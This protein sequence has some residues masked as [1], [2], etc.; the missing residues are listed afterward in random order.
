MESRLQEL[1][2]LYLKVFTAQSEYIPLIVN[3]PCPQAPTVEELWND[4]PAAVSKTARTLKPKA[5]VGSDWIPS[6]SIGLY[7]C[8]AIPSLYNA[9]TVKLDGSEPLCHPCFSSIDNALEMGL[10]PIQGHYRPYDK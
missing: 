3:P 5:D 4:L 9:E 10:P 1:K 7:Q 6:L 2:E 8:I